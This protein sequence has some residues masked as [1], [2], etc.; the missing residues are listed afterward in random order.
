MNSRLIRPLLMLPICLLALHTHANSIAVLGAGNATCGEALAR[1]AGKP[2][3]SQYVSSW[4]AGFITGLNSV[5]GTKVGQNM[6]EDT[7][8]QLW[9]AKC[10]IEKNIPKS[11]YEIGLQIYVDLMPKK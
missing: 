5:R 3:E 8:E 7:Y 6:S 11:L 10:R 4:V 1:A 9:L 2:A